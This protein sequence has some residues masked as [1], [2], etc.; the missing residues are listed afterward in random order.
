[1]SVTAVERTLSVIEAM[2]GAPEAMELSA[3]AS[4]VGLPASATHRI[5]A[6]LCERGWVTQDA[7]GAGYR[8]SLRIAVLAFRR[9]ESRM[10][11]D[12]V[13]VALDRLALRTQEYCR[14]AV[15]DGGDLVWVARSQGAPAGIR[16]EPDMGQEIVLHAT[17]NGKVWL[18]TMDD[19]RARDILDTRGLRP[20]TPV[21][22]RALTDMDSVMSEIRRVRQIGYGTALEEAE[23]ATAAVAVAF[24]AGTQPDA[25]VVG[26]ISVAGPHTR[27][28]PDRFDT[29]AQI[30]HA[31][32]AE[33]SELWPIRAFVDGAE[34]S[35]RLSA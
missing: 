14:L 15:V 28:T 20:K 26:T 4:Q 34:Q 30:L 2:A 25:P 11:R 23:P 3:I 31:A 27:I 7:V 10:V 13:Q 21:G 6:T 8:L 32:A 24:R 19:A 18:A 29:F 35:V 1:M 22:P 5:L 33:L 12:V 16:Y 17:A 9:L